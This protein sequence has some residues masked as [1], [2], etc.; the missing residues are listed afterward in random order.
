[1]ELVKLEQ[2]GLSPNE[3]KLYLVLLELGRAQ[4]G[5]IS[6][7]A[8]INRTTTYDIL[9]RLIEKGL[10]MY[11]IHANRKVF[12]PVAPGKFLEQL[13]EQQKLAEEILPELNELY[14]SVKAREEANIYRGRKGVNSVLRDILKCK[15]YVSFGSG[16][17]FLKIMKHD[18]LAFQRRKREFKVKS[19]IILSESSRK[20]DTIR[21]A[22]GR[23]RFIPDEY[24]SPTTTWVYGSHVAI[25]IWGETPIASVI[26]SKEVADSY[27][28]YFELLWK[29]AKD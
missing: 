4:A 13:K 18:F 6:K 21:F 12:Q 26:T 10:I 19:R 5:E 23:F 28:N 22:Y 15:E 14:K 25:V 24:A 2:L 9:E 8:Q 17:K 7:K 29:Q 20:A 11:V 27:R 16:D 1:M 3:A